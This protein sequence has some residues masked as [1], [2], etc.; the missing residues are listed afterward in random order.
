MC[1]YACLS[2]GVCERGCAHVCVYVCERECVSESEEGTE[3]LGSGSRV[4]MPTM[5][6]G[7]GEG[8]HWADAVPE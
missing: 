7:S 3:D 1:V 4:W 2:E 6:T 5:P 8:G